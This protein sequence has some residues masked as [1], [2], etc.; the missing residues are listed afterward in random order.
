[1]IDPVDANIV[2][3]I[4]P[5]SR[6]LAATT[7]ALSLGPSV[8]QFQEKFFVKLTSIIW[9]GSI[10]VNKVAGIDQTIALIIL[11]AFALPSQIR[12]GLKAV[13]LT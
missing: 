10:A 6:F 4:A 3:N 12:G 1:M 7:S 8:P 5:M 9:L 13:A 2:I 11:G